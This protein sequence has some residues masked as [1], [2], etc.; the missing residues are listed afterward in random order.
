MFDSILA[1]ISSNPF[2]RKLSDSYLGSTDLGEKLKKRVFEFEEDTTALIDFDEIIAYIKKLDKHKLH[3][4][5]VFALMELKLKF[6]SGLNYNEELAKRFQSLSVSNIDDVAKH[7]RSKIARIA[8]ANVQMEKR[9][10]EISKILDLVDSKVKADEAREARIRRDKEFELMLGEVL[11]RVKDER[12]ADAIEL[13]KQMVI[14]FEENPK[15]AQAFRKVEIQ[16]AR[17]LKKNQ[18]GNKE[19]RTSAFLQ[20]MGV[21]NPD[22]AFAQDL[23]EEHPFLLATKNFVLSKFNGISN[24][25]QQ[26]K[27]EQERRAVLGDIESMLVKSGGIAGAS[28]KYS[29]ALGKQFQAAKEGFIKDIGN[30]SLPGFNFMGKILSKDEFTGDAFGFYHNEKENKTIFYIGDATGHGIQASFTVAITSKLFYEVTQKTTR[31]DEIVM[32][33][34]NELKSRIQGRYFLTAVFFE[35][36]HQAKTLSYIGG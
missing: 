7:A 8:K 22:F 26:F 14:D 11:R 17:Y 9:L 15:A 3:R 19:G 35:W 34:N 4:K 16:H 5:A 36:D 10:A 33:I 27:E 12:F 6:K 25:A 2:L 32:T 21:A 13:A 1:Y 31:L 24:T 30:F 29:G 18:T 23:I 28:A 20:R